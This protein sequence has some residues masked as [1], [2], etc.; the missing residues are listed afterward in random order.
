[1]RYVRT[2]A[3]C[4]GINSLISML[5]IAEPGEALS[6]ELPERPLAEILPLLR[7]GNGFPALKVAPAQDRG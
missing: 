2:D 7:A 6:L 3:V 4:H 5:R 1:M